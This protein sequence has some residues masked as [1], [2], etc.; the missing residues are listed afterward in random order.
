MR[1]ELFNFSSWFKLQPAKGARSCQSDAGP[2]A[3]LPH[4]V[5]FRRRKVDVRLSH[6]V[7]PECLALALRIAMHPNAPGMVCSSMDA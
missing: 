3:P 6:M 5:C 2:L 4:D 7:V 1:H